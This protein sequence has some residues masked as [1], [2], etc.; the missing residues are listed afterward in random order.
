MCLALL[1]R[2]P[3]EVGGRRL[4]ES[5]AVVAS[6]LAAQ[7]S[8]LHAQKGSSQTP[9]NADARTGSTVVNGDDQASES[10]SDFT[11]DDIDQLSDCDD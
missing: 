10:N 3:P 4:T 6:Q 2:E 8:S 1:Q 11:I 7:Q 9:T 5:M